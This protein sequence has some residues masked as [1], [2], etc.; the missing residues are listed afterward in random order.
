[1]PIDYLVEK[2]YAQNLHKYAELPIPEEFLN[3]E[4][5]DR[6]LGSRF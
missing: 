4:N 5:Q 6:R 2:K 1:M 3:L